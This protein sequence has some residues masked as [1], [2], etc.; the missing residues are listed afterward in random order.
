M[1]ARANICALILL[2]SLSRY[3][4]GWYKRDRFH[5]TFSKTITILKGGLRWISPRPGTE[6]RMSLRPLVGRAGG[7]I[8]TP[9][10]PKFTRISKRLNPDMTGSSAASMEV[11]YRKP[12]KAKRPSYDGLQEAGESLTAE[13]ASRKLLSRCFRGS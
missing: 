9:F 5:S 10:D 6:Q 2:R 4:I 7:E 8:L 13:E 3:E 12:L 11:N 1:L